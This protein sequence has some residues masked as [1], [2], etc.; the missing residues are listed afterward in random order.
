MA[1]TQAKG[2]CKIPAVLLSIDLLP[3][4]DRSPGDA[5]A[6]ELTAPACEADT[7]PLDMEEEEKVTT[8]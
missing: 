8:Y 2:S 4:P 1:P 3:P 5:P 6:L 7:T